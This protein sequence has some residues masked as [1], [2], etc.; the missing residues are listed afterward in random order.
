[1]P[2]PCPACGG[3]RLV[4][5]AEYYQTQVR[6]PEA[7]PQSL[8]PLAPPLRRSI[9]P[10]TLCIALFWMAVL[11]PGFVPSERAITVCATFVA[12]G[13]AALALWLRAR[14]SDRASM[15]AYQSRR[16]CEACAWHD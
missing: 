4:P 3:P 6:Q 13:S 5:V 16:I 9:L 8:A 10:G 14:K 1:M 11:S 12:L 2:S 7:D 15:A